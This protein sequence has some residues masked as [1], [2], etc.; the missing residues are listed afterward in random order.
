MDFMDDILENL[1]GVERWTIL[2]YLKD[3]QYEIK[4]TCRELNEYVD[5]EIEELRK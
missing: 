3:I 4:D 2:A 1:D 5:K